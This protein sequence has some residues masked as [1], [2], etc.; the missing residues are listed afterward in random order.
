MQSRHSFS[1]HSFHKSMWDLLSLLHTPE[2]SI[3][4]C[5]LL[6]FSLSG[7]E[8]DEGAGSNAITSFFQK[9]EPKKEN[10]EEIKL[11]NHERLDDS[12]IKLGLVEDERDS[13]DSL[14]EQDFFM[15]P[16]C[17]PPKKIIMKNET[18]EE[19]ENFHAALK[20]Q[21]GDEIAIRV[22]ENIEKVGKNRSPVKSSQT[23]K[24]IKKMT[25]K[26]SE[27]RGTGK[28]TNYFSKNG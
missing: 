12:R 21:E 3:L 10:E 22:A 9:T 16:H 7:F 17:I 28:L 4:P 5:S 27:S 2:I 23:S 14:E 8:Y 6:S 25:Q 15:C 26:K 1:V 19:H 24:G 11:S 18:K 13:N 20:I